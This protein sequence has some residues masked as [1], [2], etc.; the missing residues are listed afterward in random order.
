MENGARRNGGAQE[1][2]KWKWQKN[3]GGMS[4][5]NRNG[6]ANEKAMHDKF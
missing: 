3:W 1:K 4:D 5:G 2:A 6:N